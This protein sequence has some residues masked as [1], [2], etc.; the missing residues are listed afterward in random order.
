MKKKGFDAEPFHLIIAAAI[1]LI[2]LVI[3]VLYF[4]GTFKK[5]R[6][7]IDDKFKGLNVDCD[8][9]GTPNLLDKCPCD[10]DE[11]FDGCNKDTSKCSPSCKDSC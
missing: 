4:T 7:I 10:A 9:D 8:C 1:L 11:V 2:T 5:E 3:L 6:G